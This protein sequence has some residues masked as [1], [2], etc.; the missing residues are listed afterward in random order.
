MR[1]IARIAAIVM[2]A[3]VAIPARAQDTTFRARARTAPDDVRG[4]AS[5]SVSE[6][7]IEERVV[8]SAPDALRLMP[9]VSI[10]QT[11]HGQASPYVRG[12]TGQQV[13][14][15]FDGVRLNNGI[16][17]QGPNQ[18]FFTVDV[19]SLATLHVVRGSASTR[20][21]ADALGGAI[22]AL[23]REPTIDP[24]R[25]GF[26]I[27]PRLIGRYGMQDVDGGAR[28]E[29]D[30][31]LGRSL[32]FLGGVR[33]REAG[34]LQAAGIVCPLSTVEPC[35]PARDPAMRRNVPMIPFIEDD[36]RT[37]RGTGFRV[38]SW[39]ERLVWR[40]SDELRVTL[41]G[42]GWHQFDSP[43]TDQCPA[44][45]APGN[46]CLTY[47]QQTRALG[48]LA[49]DV[50]PQGSE[51]AEMRIALSWQRTHEHR[52][53]DRP[54]AF[55]QNRF[56]DTIDTYGL[57][58]R[59]RTRGFLLAPEL[60][61]ALHFGAEAYS[62]VVRSEAS[63]AFTDVGLTV[64]EPR[65]QY[66]DGARFTQL[67]AWSEVQAAI[68]T[69]LIARGGARVLYAGARASADPS[70]GTAR[71]DLDVAGVAA[72]AG[73]EARVAPELTLHLN[74]D[75]GVRPPNLDDLTSR[76]QAG[77][78]FQ[79][80]N[81]A[82]REE[83]STTFELGARIEAWDVLRLDAW[84]YAMI[85]DGAMTRVP[86]EASACPPAT[87]Q[88]RASWSRYQL[89]NADDLSLILGTELALTFELR[90]IGVVALSTLSIAWGEG[91]SPTDA[92]VRVPL[93]R[94]PPFGGAV[95]VR[96]QPA[97]RG[98]ALG[99]TLRWALDQDRLAPADASDAR[100]LAGG[101]PGYAVV[102]VRAAWRFDPYLSL[103]VVLENVLDTAYRVHG[104]S[105][106]GPGRGL[107]ARV[108][109]GF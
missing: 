105:I 65:G 74:V 85:L 38:L 84:A 5:D 78:G 43:R 8:R 55:V 99:A 53:R 66:V 89:V 35:V 72:R 71:V 91:P 25:D 75:Q 12:V 62:D 11:A 73:L 106:N 28:A 48:L 93:S 41:A 14:L 51:L 108:E 70:S 80:E 9:G 68:A 1:V 63:T 47:L 26:V 42:Y 98:L 79:F 54:T 32:G 102:D 37:Q 69:W 22:I 2:I 16:F 36:G 101:T 33:Y 59:G 67:S 58:M 21:G 60:A 13:L 88:C 87:P 92:N 29:L 20:F 96:W 82:L 45:Y 7:E 90:D 18:Y 83:R 6:E 77:P 3:I 86:R 97:P 94:V 23:P 95:D 4:R 81:P 30:L 49:I 56:L 31:Q 109:A 64:R 61:I 39:D 10:Q 103:S 57:T 24:R 17:R 44:P 76:Q 52:L 27:H 104:S 40:A 19:E 50:R 34:P 15:L 107:M 46:D 100:I